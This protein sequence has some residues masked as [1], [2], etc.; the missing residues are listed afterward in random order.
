MEHALATVEKK[1]A[2]RAQEPLDTPTREADLAKAPSPSDSDTSTRLKAEV[3]DTITRLRDVGDPVPLRDALEGYLLK[4]NLGT[5]LAARLERELGLL[6]YYEFE[7]PE[8]G[9]EHL[10]EVLNLDPGSVH[11]SLDFWTALEGVYEDLSD[12]EGLL[13]A[14]NAKRR[15]AANADMGKVYGMLIGRTS[16]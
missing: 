11:E 13:T 6:Y 2:T 4:P 16:A 14:Y 8:L 10:Q 3:L 12:P 7:Q 1:I 15:L 5:S 9:L